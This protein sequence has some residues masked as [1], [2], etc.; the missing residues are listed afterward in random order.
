MKLT[1][2][3]VVPLQ[4]V[5]LFYGLISVLKQKDL[6]KIIQLTRLKTLGIYCRIYHST[7]LS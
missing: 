7:F 3:F 2:Y 4:T 6:R 1:Q 5:K